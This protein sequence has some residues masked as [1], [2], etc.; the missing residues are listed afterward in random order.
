M[1]ERLVT[2]IVE[3]LQ[4]EAAAEEALRVK[5]QTQTSGEFDTAGLAT[6]ATDATDGA[7]ADASSSKC[8]LL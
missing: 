1:F 3:K 6:D 7:K 2:R 8:T 4:A 5:T